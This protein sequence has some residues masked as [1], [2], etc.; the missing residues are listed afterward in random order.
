M[1]EKKENN[2]LDADFISKNKAALT[3]SMVELNPTQKPI[4][5]D[6]NK[7]NDKQ[8]KKYTH[9]DNSRYKVTSFKLKSQSFC[10]SCFALVYI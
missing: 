9:F 1:Q 8:D 10:V 4:I 6:V 7:D 2:Y 3:A 5:E